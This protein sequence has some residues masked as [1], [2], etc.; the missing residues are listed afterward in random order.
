MWLRFAAGTAWSG[1]IVCVGGHE[2]DLM[3]TMTS[4]MTRNV[5]VYHPEAHSGS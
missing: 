5:N 3:V 4:A 1:R 2:A